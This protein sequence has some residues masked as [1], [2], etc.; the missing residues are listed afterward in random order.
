MINAMSCYMPFCPVAQVNKSSAIVLLPSATP[1]FA[2]P[3]PTLLQQSVHFPSFKLHFAIILS[4]I[5]HTM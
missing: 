1:S 2:A 5:T 3:I 4:K